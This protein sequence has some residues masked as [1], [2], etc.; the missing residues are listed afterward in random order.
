MRIPLSAPDI[1]RMTSTPFAVLRTSHLSLGPKLEEFE[2][3]ITTITSARR[4]AIGVSS[5]TAGLHLMHTR[6]RKSA[7]AT[8]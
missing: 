5:G 6:A 1:F 8:K 4:H 7:K 3:A 2:D